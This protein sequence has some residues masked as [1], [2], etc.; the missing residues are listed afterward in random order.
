MTND[1]AIKLHQASLTFGRRYRINE[2]GNKADGRCGTLES[3]IQGE[4]WLKVAG[5]PLV[6][7][8]V[9]SLTDKGV[10]QMD[11]SPFRICGDEPLSWADGES[12]A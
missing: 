5:F 4:A 10:V 3:V 7:T 6:R 2:P 8:R 11:L 9:S 12:F 1:L